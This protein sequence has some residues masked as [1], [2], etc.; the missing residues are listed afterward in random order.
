MALLCLGNTMTPSSQPRT[1]PK[2]TIWTKPGSVI[3]LKTPAT[4]CCKGS[5]KAQEC[6]L[7]KE[8]HSGTWDRQK[9]LESKDKA[10]FSITHMTGVYAGRYHCYYESTTDWSEPSDP[11]EL[12]VTG[13]HGKPSLSSLPSP[14]VPSGGDVTLQCGSWTGF[15]RFIL[16][17]E[18][19]SQPSWTLDSQGA[20]IGGVQALLPVVQVAPSLTWKFRC[21]GYYSH[22]PHV[23]SVPSGPLELLVS[24]QHPYTPSLWVQ[25]GPMVAPGEN[26]T[27]LSLSSVD[28]CLLTKLGCMAEFSLSPV[29]SSHGGTYRCYGSLNTSLYLLSYVASA[30]GPDWYLYIL[31]GALVASVLLF[32]LVILLLDRQPQSNKYKMPG[33]KGRA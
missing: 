23:W 32:C 33:E 2:P 9:A 21:Y 20:P 30:Q 25:P 12:V 3:P 28:T 16:I 29:T 18:V 7:H 11:L 22:T 8:G 1:L 26:V 27:L 6:C 5:L 17:K 15:H 13:L 14:V 31:I 10:K 19:E 24:G 4:I